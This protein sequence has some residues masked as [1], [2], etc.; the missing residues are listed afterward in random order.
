MKQEKYILRLQE[1]TTSQ[2]IPSEYRGKI[3]GK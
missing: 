1:S 2:G 3:D